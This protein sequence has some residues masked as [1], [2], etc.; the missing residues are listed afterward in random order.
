MKRFVKFAGWLFT[1]F[2]SSGIM[3]GA[4]FF[5]L[6]TKSAGLSINLAFFAICFFDVIF[7]ILDDTIGESYREAKSIRTGKE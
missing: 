5:I 2:R 6:L 3:Y 1:S 7:S 4:F